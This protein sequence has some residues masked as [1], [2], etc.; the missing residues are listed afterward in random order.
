MNT[1]PL[2]HNARGKIFTRLLL[3]K[4]THRVKA[5]RLSRSHRATTG[6]GSTTVIT[7][8]IESVTQSYDNDSGVWVA[9]SVDN[10]RAP[11]YDT[12]D[13]S[14]DTLPIT[15]YNSVTTIRR[16]TIPLRSREVYAMCGGWAAAQLGVL[17]PCQTKHNYTISPP[18]L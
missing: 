1:S 3:Y 6:G 11:K 13:N 16:I 12:R 18:T 15:H 2:L 17:I 7:E 5:P 14:D 8:S 10:V 4:S 9:G